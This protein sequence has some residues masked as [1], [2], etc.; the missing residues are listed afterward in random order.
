MRNS[1]TSS[2]RLRSAAPFPR[3]SLLVPLE[4]PLLLL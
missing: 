1:P 4:L 3:P 2:A